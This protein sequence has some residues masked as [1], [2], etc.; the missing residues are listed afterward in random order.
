MNSIM[1]VE[2]AVILIII[3]EISSDGFVDS[4][5][6]R[7]LRESLT[8]SALFIG[9]DSDNCFFDSSDL[10]REDAGLVRQFI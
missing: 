8:I 1:F 10:G 4:K 6:N 3:L 9:I 7:A 5:V 2:L